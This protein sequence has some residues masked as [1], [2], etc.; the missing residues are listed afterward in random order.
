MQSEVICLVNLPVQKGGVFETNCPSWWAKPSTTPCGKLN[1]LWAMCGWGDWNCGTRPG[2]WSHKLLQHQSKQ[3]WLYECV[4]F[5]VSAY[6][7]MFLLRMLW[8]FWA[9]GRPNYWS[10]RAFQ[11]VMWLREIVD[12]VPGARGVLTAFKFSCYGL[13]EFF[14]FPECVPQDLP[15][16]EFCK[17]PVTGVCV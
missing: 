4:V 1:T 6:G 14:F 7:L 8:W 15:G 5:G 12:L 17:L 3:R 11:F 13:T 2:E 16:A 10:G 9:A